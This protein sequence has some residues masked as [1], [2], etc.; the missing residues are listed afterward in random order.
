M[1]NQFVMV[2]VAIAFVARKVR[3]LAS[4]TFELT[5]SSRV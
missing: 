5:N 2:R 3:A 4:L 1:C